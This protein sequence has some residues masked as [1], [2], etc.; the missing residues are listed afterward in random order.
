MCRIRRLCVSQH[1]WE[2][3]LCQVEDDVPF[4]L[5]EWVTRPFVSR[6]DSGFLGWQLVLAELALNFPVTLHS[7]ADVENQTLLSLNLQMES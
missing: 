1:S 2:N 4:N 3:G 7:K 5:P 6:L